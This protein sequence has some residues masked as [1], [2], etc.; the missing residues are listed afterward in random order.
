M[1]ARISVNEDVDYYQLFS[2]LSLGNL[3]LPSDDIR[4][5][6][7]VRQSELVLL[8]HPTNFKRYNR[9]PYHAP[10]MFNLAPL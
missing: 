1:L 3:A 4:P 7:K 6:E 9:F 8:S 2:L 10:Q 5:S